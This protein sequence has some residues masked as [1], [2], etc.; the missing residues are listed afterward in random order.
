MAK[1]RY[2]MRI[3]RIKRRAINL[4]RIRLDF[5]NPIPWK[6]QA[7]KLGF[8]D[9]EIEGAEKIVQEEFKLNEKK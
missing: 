8:S 7:K 9:K 4:L 1:E 5:D 6:E 3:E 2:G